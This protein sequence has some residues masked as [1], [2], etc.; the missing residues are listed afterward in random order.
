[1][2]DQTIKNPRIKQGWLRVVLFVL[3]FGLIT[4]LV[5]IPALMEVVGVK[6]DDLLADPIHI[7]AS[8]LTGPY[9]W[10]MLVL[11]A[12]ISLISVWIFRTFSQNPRTC[13]RPI[14]WIPSSSSS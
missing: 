8:Q 6:K 5:T 10:L 7:L 11:E 1:M 12:A 9:L 2:S 3:A 13:N 4:L 14:N